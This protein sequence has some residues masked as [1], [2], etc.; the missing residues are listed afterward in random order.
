MSAYADSLIIQALPA[1]CNFLEI[2]KPTKFF[3][4]II[5]II[6]KAI[7]HNCLTDILPIFVVYLQ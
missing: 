1:I 3:V 4:I 5:I 6:I 7:E 2:S